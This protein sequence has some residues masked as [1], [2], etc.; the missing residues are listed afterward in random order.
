LRLI[1]ELVV[2][3]H[4]DYK[5]GIG[6]N[7]F[8]Q[9]KIKNTTFPSREVAKKPTSRKKSEIRHEEWFISPGGNL[10]G[11]SAE[12]SGEVGIKRKT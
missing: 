2:K 10:V 11:D 6:G 4:S 1:G 5:G 3:K 7:A 8:K 9:R 12:S